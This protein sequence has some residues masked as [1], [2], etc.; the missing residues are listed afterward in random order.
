M[1]ELGTRSTGE[2]L[3]VPPEQRKYVA[4]QN[5]AFGDRII[6]PGEIGP[7]RTGQKLTGSLL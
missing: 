2:D 6:R 5:L 1:A 4:L 3:S 7:D